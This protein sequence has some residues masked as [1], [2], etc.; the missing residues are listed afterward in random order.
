MASKRLKVELLGPASENQDVRLESLAQ[1]L[2]AIYSALLAVDQKLVSKGKPSAYYRVVNLS[3][4]SPASLVIEAIPTSEEVDLG[5]R[6][7]SEFVDGW[8][9][10]VVKKQRPARF[11]R[12]LTNKF[13]RIRANAQAVPF[14]AFSIEGD[15]KRIE[16][17][18]EEY[19]SLA[20]EAKPEPKEIIGS[21][22]GHAIVLSFKEGHRRFEVY[23]IAGPAFVVCHYADELI[24]EVE[25]ASNKWV[26]VRGKM[27]YPRGGEYPTAI[28]VESIEVH[29][30]DAELPTLDDLL[31]IAPDA[32]GT[33][34][35]EEF[36]RQRRDED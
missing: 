22:K 32:T 13:R 29:P 35:S 36:V 24:Q 21:I 31:G 19:P 25:N 18:E 23:P 1:E 4:S 7:I 3:H 28:T 16:I 10:I 9:Q 20:P 33:L 11:D 15:S 34:S 12:E 5:D 6:I 26:T 2:N 27:E 14:I 8:E 17:R 30:R